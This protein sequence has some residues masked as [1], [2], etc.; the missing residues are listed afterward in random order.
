MRQ[1]LKFQPRKILMFGL[2]ALSC[3]F[4]LCWH[5]IFIFS[6][7][8]KLVFFRVAI[9]SKPNLEKSYVMY[10][11]LA[12][13]FSCLCVWCLSGSSKS[14]SHSSYLY[15]PTRDGGK[16]ENWKGNNH[17]D[18][19]L[20]RTDSISGLKSWVLKSTFLFETDG[21]KWSEKLYFEIPSFR[22]AAAQC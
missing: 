12:L 11:L 10:Y 14:P 3:L 18:P 9:T 17:L 21:E 22:V 16:S 15:I 7:C 8:I 2:A 13:G 4:R 6:I 20:P 1:K 5:L 19:D